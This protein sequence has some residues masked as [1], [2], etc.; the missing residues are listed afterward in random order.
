MILMKRGKS[1]ETLNGNHEDMEKKMEIIAYKWK[2]QKKLKKNDIR[3]VLKKSLV[4]VLLEAKKQY[5]CQERSEE[6]QVLMYY[7]F[8]SSHK[9]KHNNYFHRMNNHLRVKLDNREIC[10]NKNKA[11]NF[12]DGFKIADIFQIKREFWNKK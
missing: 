4:S 9:E 1:T 6:E 2:M 7:R 3:N 8:G 11:G 10:P 5:R 12:Q